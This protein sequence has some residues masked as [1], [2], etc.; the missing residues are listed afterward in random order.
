MVAPALKKEA[1]T[2][3]RQRGCSQRR[4]ARL[5][6]TTA[7]VLRYRSRR[8]D[9]TPIRDRLRALAE[10][11]P[12]FGYRRLHQLLRREGIS[13][14]IKKTHRLYRCEGLHLRPKRRR[15]LKTALRVPQPAPTGP[16]QRWTLDFIHD[17]LACG[18]S[19]RALNVME[20]WSREALEIEVDTSITGHRVVRVLEHLVAKRGKP[21]VLQLDN[22]PELRGIALDQWAYKN[23]VKLDFIEP[24]KPTQN[25]KI[26][27]FNGRLRDECL[28]QEWFTSL[29]HAR[30]VL[31]DWKEDYNHV[32]P[33]SALGYKTPVEWAQSKTDSSTFE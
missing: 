27:S 24:G 15:R 2:Y 23:K 9:V 8:A 21:E 32:R 19:F 20:A 25:A 28:N 18:R 26:E 5:A 13:L 1:A 7:S 33:H 4:A 31:A 6:G 10:E 22:G 14:N 30:V 16:N 3:L 12:R 17:N 29:D 11:R